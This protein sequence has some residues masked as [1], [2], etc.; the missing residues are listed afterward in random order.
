[1]IYDQNISLPVIE[2]LKSTY[3]S[4]FKKFKA[5][6]VFSYT[7]AI[8]I[9]FISKIL[10]DHIIQQTDFDY[11]SLVFYMT[12]SLLILVVLNIY[13]YRLFMLGTGELFKVSIN[14]LF[15]IIKNK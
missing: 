8:P 4:V 14:E 3:F 11:V 10:P 9:Y 7:L 5:W 12:I 2:I 6:L 13:I 1:M 15:Y